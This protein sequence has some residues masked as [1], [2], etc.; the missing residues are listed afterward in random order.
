[1]DELARV[2]ALPDDTMTTGLGRFRDLMGFEW[3]KV[4]SVRST[5]G[6]VAVA[7]LLAVA[8]GIIT[9]SFEASGWNRKH[10][11]ISTISTPW[12]TPMADFCSRS[13]CSAVSVFSL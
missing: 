3:I 10:Q 8:V 1:M 12:R 5:Y 6:V 4:R 7:F 2:S 9:S 11:T 13:C